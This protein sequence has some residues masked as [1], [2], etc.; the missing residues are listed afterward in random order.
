[1]RIN[2]IGIIIFCALITGAGFFIS[3]CNKKIGTDVDTIEDIRNVGAAENIRNDFTPI[4]ISLLTEPHPILGSDGKY[5][6]VYELQLTNA[7]SFTWQINSVEVLNAD[8]HEQ[9]LA[10]FSGDTVTPNNQ[11]VPGRIPSETLARSE[12]SVFF[13]T[14]S[15]D[16]SDDIPEKI[17]HRLKITVPGGIPEGFLSFLSLPPGTPELIQIEGESKV[18][19]ADAVVIGPPLKGTKWVAADGCCTSERH[20]RAVMPINGKLAISQRFAIDWEKLND[21]NHIYVGDPLDVT[22]YFCYGEEILAVG[23]G[24]VV[25]AVDKYDDQ[26]PGQLPPGIPLEEADGNYVVIDLGG[27]NFAFYAHMIKGSVAVEVGDFVT[28]GQVIGLVG[29]TGNTSAPHLHFHMMSGPSTF[30]SNGIPYMI[31]EYDLLGRAPSIEAF[32]EAEINGTPLKILPVN[33][34]GIHK[35]DLPLDLGI[36][37]FPK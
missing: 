35:D 2:K 16:S 20:V 4:I 30:G 32:D 8:N 25:V 26:I 23:E 7:N 37:N 18:T 15:V 17:T 5:H 6:L 11:I 9:I 36:L 13:I 10:V 31:Y 21:E 27:G 19:N 12:T 29:N 3:G 34:P 1:M 24:R 33:T 28:R 22:N 14:F